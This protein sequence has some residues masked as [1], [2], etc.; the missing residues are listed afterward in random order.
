MQQ[1]LLRFYTLGKR[2]LHGLPIRDWLLE[3][4]E[5]VGVAGGTT[6]RAHAGYGRDKVQQGE[7]LLEIGA[8]HP[9]E[10]EFATDRD[11]ADRLIE[12]VR[13]ENTRIFY[14]CIPVEFGWLGA[15]EE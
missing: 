14:V 8:D 2:K 15:S 13:A 10:I 9:F 3:C 4:A 1:V 12:L 11:R 5:K 6:F 7:N